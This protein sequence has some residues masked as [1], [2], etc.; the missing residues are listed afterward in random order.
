METHIGGTWNQ[1]VDKVIEHKEIL[2][3]V[4]GRG[5]EKEILDKV[6]E[7]LWRRGRED[8]A[9]ILVVIPYPSH[10]PTYSQLGDRRYAY[11]IRIK[12]YKNNREAA[13]LLSKEL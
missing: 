12:A 9:T 7:R 8:L 13:S 1:I 4:T 11:F 10:P 5:R 2:F 6:K 3:L